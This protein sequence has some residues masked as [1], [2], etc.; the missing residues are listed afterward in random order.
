[1]T[2]TQHGSLDPSH[3]LWPDIVPSDENRND[4]ANAARLLAYYG[5]QLV[6]TLPDETGPE[7]AEAGIYSV[8]STGMLSRRRAQALVDRAGKQY[9][10]ECKRVLGEHSPLYRRCL[11]HAIHMRGKLAFSAVRKMMTAVVVGLLEEDRLPSGVVVA[12]ESEIDADLSCIGTPSGVLELT[13]GRILPPDEA[14]QKLVH[15]WHRSRIR[16]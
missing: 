11:D 6:I 12:K 8:T 3:P 14:R 4:S 7:D 1:M 16:A 5:D 10:A 2:T 9:A 13:T 15:Q